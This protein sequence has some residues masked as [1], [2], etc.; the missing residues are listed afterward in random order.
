MQVAA[1]CSS[2]RGAAT[3]ALSHA[4]VIR[5]V[6][7]RPAIEQPTEPEQTYGSA[8]ATDEWDPG[9]I[10][11]LTRAMDLCDELR[12]DQE[13]LRD[14]HGDPR[15]YQSTSNER[16][17]GDPYVRMRWLL[18]KAPPAI[19]LSF[20]ALLGDVIQNLRAALE[21]SAWAAA[22]AEARKS[23][24]R[25]I[26]FP[27]LDRRSDYEKWVSGRSKIFSDATFRVLE[28]AQPFQANVEQLHPLR[29][30]RTLSN[31][32]KHRLLSVVDHAHIQV[33]VELDPMPPTYNWW[34]AEGP[35]QEGGMLAELVFPRPPFSLEIDVRPS[36]GWYESVAYEEPTKSVRWLRLD[37][38]MNEIASFA[39]NTVGLMS[40]ARLGLSVEDVDEDG[41]A[42]PS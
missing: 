14:L 11:K 4:L 32:D 21:Y 18:T 2:S 27:I 23:S 30:L 16:C 33:G 24:P 20:A 37:E 10:A 3:T 6:N 5:L 13:R 29:I 34:V 25:R 42:G 36:F 1:H 9:I 38:M 8:V 12:A 19:P 31:T 39:V 7:R 40:G 26:S 22:S 15:E 41:S 28:W 17:H 35:V